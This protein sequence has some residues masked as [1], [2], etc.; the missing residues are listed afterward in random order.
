M[1]LFRLQ[2]GGLV[3]GYFDLGQRALQ[4][5]RRSGGGSVRRDQLRDVRPVGGASVRHVPVRDAAQAGAGATE[6]PFRLHEGQN[7][8]DVPS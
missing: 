1:P 6:D 3:N 2:K 7:Q 4:T 8:D 5:L